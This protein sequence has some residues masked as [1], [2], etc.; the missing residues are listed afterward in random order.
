MSHLYEVKIYDGKG[1]LKE[2]VKPK[3]DY[4]TTSYGNPKNQKRFN[5]IPS[6]KKE[7]FDESTR[8]EKEKEI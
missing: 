3:I 5:K 8:A 4:D 1:N 7:K 6:E 2:V